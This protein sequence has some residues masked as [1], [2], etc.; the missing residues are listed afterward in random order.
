MKR[1]TL[2]RWLMVFALGL[3]LPTAL[4]ATVLI[5][6]N[7]MEARRSAEA[8]LL[9]DARAMAAAIDQDVARQIA[10]AQAIAS[11]DALGRRDWVRVRARIER[12]RLGSRGWVAIS[13]RS[14]RGLVN[15]SA[16]SFSMPAPVPDTR[17]PANIQTA[18]RR[19]TATVSDLFIGAA[20]HRAVVSVDAPAV[21]DPEQVVVSLVLD[22]ERFREIMR[23]QPLP[24]E[25]FAT[26]VGGDHRVIT[27]T[28]AAARFQGT[29]ATAAMIRAM[30]ARKAGVVPSRSLEGEPT[31]V[32]YAPSSLSEW[33]VMMVAPR[34]EFEA[35][36]WRMAAIV[37]CVFLLVLA[38]SLAIARHASRRIAGDIGDL[39]RDALT[40]SGGGLVPRRPASIANIDRVQA[41]LSQAS[42]E[43][44]T[45]AERQVLLIHELNHRVKNTLATVQALAVQTFRGGDRDRARTFEQ[46]LVALGA[47]HDLLTRTVWT[48]VDIKDVVGQC[49]DPFDGRVTADGPSLLLPPEAALALC[50]ILHEL[51]TN[52][53][54]YGSLSRPEGR[55]S[56]D[57][58]PAGDAIALRWCETG[59]PPV[60]PAVRPGFGTRLIDRL[61]RTELNGSLERVF[62]PGGLI[63]TARL[64]PPQGGR[65]AT[66]DL[67][68]GAGPG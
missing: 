57:W 35:P 14:A 64:R 45:R 39:E 5:G 47:A 42:I 29:P 8:A 16:G 65:W 31:V 37:L 62:D 4:V 67:A 23:D 50:M 53:L 32:A 41:A 60:N 55:V 13:D 22:P 26:L 33:T 9:A 46:R 56:M 68:P 17:R 43:L 38:F 21:G 1:P 54:K 10:F 30:K 28:R 63:V 49:G 25:G 51:Q 12:L 61:I 3:T 11:S 36:I 7:V 58:S 34:A 24:P 48:A 18:L 52:S 19:G 44:D 40:V 27:R 15:T 66:P 20:T 59:G 6:W 2:R